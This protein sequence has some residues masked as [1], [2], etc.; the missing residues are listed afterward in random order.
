MIPNWIVFTYFVFQSTMK[1][2]FQMEKE[3]YIQDLADIKNMM[4]RSSR[5]LSL[6]GMTGVTIGTWALIGTWN[7]WEVLQ[8]VDSYDSEIMVFI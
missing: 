4:E 8:R 2:N 6:S 7:V 3:K 1:I 5:F